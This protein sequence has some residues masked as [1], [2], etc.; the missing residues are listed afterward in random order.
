M[1]NLKTYDLFL[2]HAWKHNTDYY[3]LEKML[4]QAPLFSWRNY[5]V[6]VHNPLIDPG[7]KAGKKVLTEE[8]DQQ[9]KPTNCVI[10]LAGMYASYSEWIEKEI[11]IAN[12]YNKPII[13]IEPWGQERVPQ[14]VQDNAIEIVKWN[15]KSIITAIRN[16]SI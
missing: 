9:V 16:N 14:I 12:N 4:N 10:I 3:K 6:P 7:S 15:T 8:L 5:S 11:Q 13:G 1:P 2:S